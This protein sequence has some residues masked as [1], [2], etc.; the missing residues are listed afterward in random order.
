MFHVRW[1]KYSLHCFGKD[2]E[3]NEEEEET[4]DETR[5]NLSSD[6][7]VGKRFV[8]FPSGETRNWFR[9]F[10]KAETCGMGIQGGRRRPQDSHL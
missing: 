4:V 8:R 1:F 6:I 3:G 9:N 2:E 10:S 5:D 7:T